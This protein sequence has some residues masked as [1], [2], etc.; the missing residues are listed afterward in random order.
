MVSFPAPVGGTPLPVDFAP[1][2]LF[3]VLYGLLIP[4]EAYRLF[5]R[6]SRTTLLIG[7]VAFAIE[8]IVIFSLR[9]AQ[10]RNE[11]RR[12]SNGLI[13]YMQASFALGSIGIASDLVNIVRCLLVNPT[14]GPARFEECAAA[15]TKE[16]MM[17]P[18]VE[19]V[20]ED[21][22]K[23][24]FWI[25]RFTDFYGLAF[26]ASTVPG[27]IANTHFH[28]AID[29][30]KE[31]DN[32]YKLRVVSS[33]VCIVLTIGLLASVVWGKM[34]L[35]RISLRGVKVITTVILLVNVIAVYRL[36]VM[37]L[38]ENS[39][40]DPIRLNTP[41]GKAAFYLLHVLPEW[42]ATAT[43]FG[44][45]VR[46]TFGTGPFGDWRGHDETEKEKKKRL[47]RWEKKAAKKAAKAGNSRGDIE[48]SEKR[49]EGME[50]SSEKGLV[51][52]QDNS[53]LIR[54]VKGAS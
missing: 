29:S 32:I 43:L 21:M 22:P 52:K 40:T 18:P 2:V 17:E 10:S 30:Q 16:C 44:I 7:T 47:K 20:H 48:L 24:R 27:I 8:R 45:N 25:R 33:S 36:A 51:E 50:S 14:Y 5:H 38:R 54:E 15:R 1:S 41:G 6:R 35:H 3:A 4:L 46:K 31:A 28:K 23:Q 34:N 39:L 19:G 9:A 42:L 11:K 13:D 49:E 26:L 12:F 37:P 53:S